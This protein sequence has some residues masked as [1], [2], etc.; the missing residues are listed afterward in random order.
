MYKD[1]INLLKGDN[2]EIMEA[3]IN[4][5]GTEN[6]EIIS[7][8]DLFDTP[9]SNVVVHIYTTNTGKVG[10]L[11]LIRNSK[12]DTLQSLE[13]F[14][15]ENNISEEAMEQ[16]NKDFG[17][18][19]NNIESLDDI[20][21]DIVT[22]LDAFDESE[23]AKRVGNEDAY[24]ALFF[25]DDYVVKG[26]DMLLDNKVVSFSYA[27]R[28]HNIVTEKLNYETYMG[29]T[30]KEVSSLSKE[31]GS[32]RANVIIHAGNKYELQSEDEIRELDVYK[33]GEFEIIAEQLYGDY[34]MF[35]GYEIF[36]QNNTNYILVTNW[37]K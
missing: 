33:D 7:I 15:E 25:P 10:R 34:G 24:R 17:L 13:D 31:Y 11:A 29:Y 22:S 3:M 28:P 36:N 1:Q 4:Q 5:F 21:F 30:A 2:K 6:D 14:A 18:P 37:V 26:Y 19:Y 23:V 27:S 12:D 8:P 16:F 32:S 35:E 9:L 20:S